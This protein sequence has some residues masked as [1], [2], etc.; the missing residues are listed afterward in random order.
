M[1]EI[2]KALEEHCGSER[3]QKFVA[4]LKGQSKTSGR[5]LFWQEQLLKD[6]AAGTGKEAPG[7]LEGVLNLFR[8]PSIAVPCPSAT[9]SLAF[10]TFS[11]IRQFTSINQLASG[12]SHVTDFVVRIV[13]HDERDACEVADRSAPNEREDVADQIL[14]ALS[15]GLIRFLE[16]QR[17]GGRSVRAFRVELLG[18]QG[19]ET[20]LKPYKFSPALCFVLEDLLCETS[21]GRELPQKLVGIPI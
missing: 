9:A 21:A 14:L 3:F 13:R 16:K 12:G 20:D 7:D 19:H 6:F 1:S 5:L 8:R 17:V 2:L 11:A 10:P 18:Y 15:E 4:V